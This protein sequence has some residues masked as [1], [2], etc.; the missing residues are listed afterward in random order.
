MAEIGDKVFFPAY[1]KSE[2]GANGLQRATSGVSSLR[3]REPKSGG[4]PGKS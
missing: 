1:A 3:L 4:L 2:A